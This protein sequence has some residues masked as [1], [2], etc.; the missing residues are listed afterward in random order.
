MTDKGKTM[1]DHTRNR[2]HAGGKL[3]T[4]MLCAG[5]LLLGACSG[6]GEAPGDGE[7]AS[8]TTAPSVTTTDNDAMTEPST[9]TIDAETVKDALRNALEGPVRVTGSALYLA[10]EEEQFT[11]NV[12]EAANWSMSEPMELSYDDARN[13]FRSVNGA[14][15]Q[16][17]DTHAAEESES[18]AWIRNDMPGMNLT[19]ELLQ[20]SL[21]EDAL[22]SD[23]LSTGEQSP[24]PEWLNIRDR[25]LDD[26]AISTDQTNGDWLLTGEDGDGYAY[27]LRVA[28]D[29]DGRVSLLRVEDSYMIEYDRRVD[30][31]PIGVPETYLEGEDAGR[32]FWLRTFAL[33]TGL[34]AQ[35]IARN[36]EAIAASEG[37]GDNVLDTHLESAFGEAGCGKDCSLDL[38]TKTFSVTE[39]GYTCSAAFIPADE[40]WLTA[41]RPVCVQN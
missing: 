27:S 34:E 36:A 26:A 22:D 1:T 37:T 2:S 4:A 8:A 18:F 21:L 30:V 3:R 15:Y 11:L 12:D 17:I 40:G 23:A 5:V 9:K 33:M 29:D 19:P 25:F 39:L 16:F 35:A 32:L 38:A 24:G 31:S 14:L 10:G 13:E 28:L 6:G 20:I 7:N 41:S